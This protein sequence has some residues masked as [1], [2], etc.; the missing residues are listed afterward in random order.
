LRG[1]GRS[2]VPSAARRDKLERARALRVVGPEAERIL[3][4]AI[5]DRQLGGWKFRRQRPVGPFIVDFICLDAA[6]IVELDGR[7]HDGQTAY[8]AERTLYLRSQGYRVQRYPN[9]EV[10][11]N[12]EG[13][14]AD[15]LL[16]LTP[17]PSPAEAGE[18]L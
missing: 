11:H 8:D 2:F 10:L 9:A 7:H 6:L 12:L 13:V 5:R 18:G 3:W 15:I 1:S 4:R 17:N 14:L 16:A